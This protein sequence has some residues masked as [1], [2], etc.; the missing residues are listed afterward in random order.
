[1]KTCASLLNKCKITLEDG[2]KID[3]YK[4]GFFHFTDFAS[5]FTYTVYN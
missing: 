2:Q 3:D 1:M 4:N 5:V